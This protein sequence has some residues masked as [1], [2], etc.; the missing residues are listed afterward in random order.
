M[1]VL[2]TGG[3]GHIGSKLIQT[4]SA[5]KIIVVDNFMTQRYSSLF[6]LPKSKNI[7]FF[8]MNVKDITADW[9]REIGPVDVIIHL[10]A[11]TDAAG[12]A[13]NREE[14]FNNNLESTKHIAGL[15][16]DLGIK[17]VFP[18]STSVYGSQSEL[19][20]ENCLDLL[21]QSPYAESKLS[22][23][24]FLSG[25]AK[26]GLQVA[27]LRFGTIHGASSGMR[28]HTAVNKFI[29]QVKLGLSITVWR[30][31]L[32]QKRPYLSL[33]DCV[34]AI[35][36]VIRYSLF[37]GEIYNVVTNNWTV[38]EIVNTIKEVSNIDANIVFVDSAIMN[39]LSY[40]V[41]S[42]KFQK[43]GFRFTGKLADDI[44]ESFDLLSGINNA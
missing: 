36:H 32:N 3:M 20:D 11:T 13:N 1:K 39:Q 12:N 27:I 6:N 28:F 8:E 16:K 25:M 4:L 44:R 31:A 26:D 43:T 14:L 2:V 24:R 5:S 18:S 33:S 34:L 23:E 21:P 22:E 15:A 7:F 37:S 17:L 9:L 42:E 41:S 40:E 19:V 30:T 35:E 29:F 38:Q 10:S